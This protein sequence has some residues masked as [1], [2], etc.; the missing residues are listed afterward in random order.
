MLERL[1]G[2]KQLSTQEKTRRLLSEFNVYS[3][4]TYNH[5]V[6]VGGLTYKLVMCD[7]SLTSEVRRKVIGAGFLHDVG[8][9][10]IPKR[11]LARNI[12]TTIS[13]D[14]I[15]FL[16]LHGK[17]GKII[18]DQLGFE[19]IYG[20]IADQHYIGIETDPPKPEDL[21]RRH[22]LVPYVSIPDFI[23]SSLDSSR[24]QEDYKPK[25]V[26]ND[27]RE[28][29][30]KEYLPPSLRPAFEEMIQKVFPHHAR[31]ASIK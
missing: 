7:P 15:N 26:I 9:L 6:S 27:I 29:F 31:V 30:D 13:D 25:R 16:K 4:P 10:A 11:I 28:R 21:K 22:P 2:L 24:L 12:N 3:P 20:I 19:E 17:I 8:K 23:V 5:L 1:N 18:L 14:D